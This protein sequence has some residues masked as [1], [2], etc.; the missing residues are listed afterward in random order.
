MKVSVLVRPAASVTISVMVVL[1]VCPATG[2][3]LMLRFAPD[4]PSEIP[5]APSSAS[6]EEVAVTV[7]A[8]ADVSRS[9][10]V[11]ASGPTVPPP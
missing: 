3:R 5:D 7:S 1:P 11:N 8:L 4:P 9:D 10:T 6:F 2:A